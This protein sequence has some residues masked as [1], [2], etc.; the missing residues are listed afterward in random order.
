MAMRKQSAGEVLDALNK[1]D[2]EVL[3]HEVFLRCFARAAK[4][5]ELSGFNRS[6]LF[7]M[8]LAYF[9][10]VPDASAKFLAELRAHHG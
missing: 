2:H 3:A 6:S 1:L 7:R 9:L 5:K 8:A 10:L 4:S